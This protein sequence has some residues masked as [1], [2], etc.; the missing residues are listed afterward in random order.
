M[1]DGIRALYFTAVIVLSLHL[2]NPSQALLWLTFFL[3]LIIFI[4]SVI[5][6][7]GTLF[8]LLLLCWSLLLCL[9]LSLQLFIDERVMNRADDIANRLDRD[10]SIVSPEWRT[11]V[12]KTAQ[13]NATCK[14]FVRSEWISLLTNRLGIVVILCPYDTYHVLFCVASSALYY[15]N[16]VSAV[17]YYC[18]IS[19]LTPTWLL[20]LYF[21]SI[22]ASSSRLLP[23]GEYRWCR[24]EES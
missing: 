12:N 8:W 9:L 2:A 16:P 10:F 23:R 24:R 17:H 1:Y 20:C 4:W 6:C 18:V 3:F 22:K 13:Y 5:L 11:W 15:C 14:T 19:Y 7:Y 21:N